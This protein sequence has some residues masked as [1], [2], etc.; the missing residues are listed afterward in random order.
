MLPV[1]LNFAKLKIAVAGQGEL[2]LKRLKKLEKSG[3]MDVDIY[4]SNIDKELLAYAGAKIKTGLPDAMQISSYNI[5]MLAG[6]SDAVAFP[7]AD[8]ARD[9]KVL[10]NVEDRMEY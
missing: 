7:L 5:L 1:V 3:A 9:N 8:I 2:L 4:A 10:V 6:F